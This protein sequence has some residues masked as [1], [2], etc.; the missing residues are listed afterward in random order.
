MKIKPVVFTILAIV[1]FS[2]ISGAIDCPVG[3]LNED[4]KVDLLDL[5]LSS[6]GEVF[7]SEARSAAARD[8]KIIETRLEELSFPQW[9]TGTCEF[10]VS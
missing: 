9:A 1:S 5:N 2:G 4:C 3:D 6:T 8:I 10:A 7:Y